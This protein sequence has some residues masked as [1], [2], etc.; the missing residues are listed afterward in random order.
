VALPSYYPP[1]WWQVIASPPEFDDLGNRVAPMPPPGQAVYWWLMPNETWLYRE[2]M[3]WEDKQ[4]GAWPASQVMMP[5]DLHNIWPG[6][7]RSI[8]H[9]DF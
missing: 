5:E 7:Q 9:S 2:D 1:E 4:F 8:R 3:P 6:K